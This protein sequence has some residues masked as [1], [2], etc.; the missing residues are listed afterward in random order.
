MTAKTWIAVALGVVITGTIAGRARAA[1]SRGGTDKDDIA[2]FAGAKITLSEAVAAAERQTGAKAIEAGVEN[3]NGAVAFEVKV[4]NGNSVQ[5]VIVDA[6]SG[7]VLQVGAAE[8]KHEHEGE[9]DD[10]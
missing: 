3:K 5:N 9:E 7:R 4:A 1:E 2:T 6:Q 8:D 10:D